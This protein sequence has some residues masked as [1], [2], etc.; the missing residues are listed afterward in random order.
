MHMSLF[1]VDGIRHQQAHKIGKSEVPTGCKLRYLISV[2]HH[3][4]CVIILFGSELRI[5]FAVASN[6]HVAFVT[7]TKLDASRDFSVEGENLV[8][9]SI[10][11]MQIP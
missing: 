2:L 11:K 5:A 7:V 6:L 10:Q 1:T 3:F 4:A 9:L 8:C